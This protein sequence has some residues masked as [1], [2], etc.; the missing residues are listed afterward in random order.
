MMGGRQP[1]S[2]RRKAFK[3][4]DSAAVTIPK[5]GL[6]EMGLSLGDVIGEELPAHFDPETGSYSVTIEQE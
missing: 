6:D 1:V 4:G 2:G 3:H 5:Q